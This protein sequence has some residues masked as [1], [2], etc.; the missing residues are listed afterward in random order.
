MWSK[1]IRS[2]WL[3]LSGLTAGAIAGFLGFGSHDLAKVFETY[4]LPVFFA[5]VGFELRDEFTSG[6]F[7][8]RK[9]VAAPAFA[10]ILGVV[11]SALS[12]VL[13]AGQKGWAVPTA[14]DITL[15]LA[16]ISLFRAQS[17]KAR[18]LALATIDDLI[19]LV[20]IAILF[21]QSINFVA[22]G[23][24]MVALTAFW[25]AQR[26]GGLLA[27][28]SIPLAGLAIMATAHAQVQTSLV[29]FLIGFVIVVEPL[30]E[31]VAKISEYAILPVFGFLLL[32]STF[33]GFDGKIA[34]VVMLAVA[35]RPLGKVLG[36]MLGAWVASKFTG[37]RFAF[38]DWYQIGTLGGIGLTVSLLL[39]ELSFSNSGDKQAAILGTLI[40]LALSVILFRLAPK[41]SMRQVAK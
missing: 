18:F 24:A 1:E 37:E 30:K 16:A 26:T 25:L 19:G 17:L 35:T 2:T 7:R 29:G 4:C 36:I 23:V 27:Y 5:V 34:I 14:T 10:A 3:L 22:L 38:Q 6:Y 39:S 33:L 12:Y 40:A 13:I 11:F 20:I 8:E 15:G 31:L 21:T 32:S 41:R 9:R 28:V